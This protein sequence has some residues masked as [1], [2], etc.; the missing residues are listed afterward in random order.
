MPRT[1]TICNHPE[2]A[3]INQALV[4]NNPFRYVSK[5][6]NVSVASLHRHKAEHIPATLA[7]AKNISGSFQADSLL[8]QLL[9]LN[10]TTLEILDEARSEKDSELALKAIARAEKQLE[11]QARL[12]GELH[13]GQTINILLIPEWLSLRTSILRA[14]EPYQ[15]ARNAVLLSLEKVDYAGR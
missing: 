14:L 11:L 10:K 7:K 2:V 12:L 8:N 9:N 6:F 4:D 5:Q 13:E 15:D 3:A 1:C